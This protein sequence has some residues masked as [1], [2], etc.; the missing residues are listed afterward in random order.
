[1]AAA[2][3]GVRLVVLDPEQVVR[4]AGATGLKRPAPAGD[5]AFGVLCGDTDTPENWLR[6]GAALSAVSMLAARLGLT[7]TPSSAAVQLRRSR[8]V[9]RQVLPGS[10]PYVAVRIG[11]RKASTVDAR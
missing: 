10:V 1:R 5:D 8:A 7:V 2:A 6:A 11:A 9:L 3:E 4:L